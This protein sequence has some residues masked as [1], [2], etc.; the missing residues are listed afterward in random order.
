M[1]KILFLAANPQ[2]TTSLRLDEECRAIDQ[3]VRVSEFR[4]QF[5]IK[6]HWAVRIWD[7][8]ELLLRHTPHI[9]HFSG[10]G[11]KTNEIILQDNFGASQPVSAKA[12][13][14]LF[15]VLKD[16]IRCVVLNACYSQ[17]QA[18]AI[19][20]NIDC[21]VGM[22]KAILDTSAISFAAAFYRALGYGRDVKTAFD[23]GCLQID[24]DNLGM[25]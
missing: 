8:Q 24:L 14:K 21:V 20:K 18:E 3:A 25:V 6:S 4:D 15:G 12:L 9:V 22:S 7:L 13:E 5:D 19:A 2:D 1:I 23:L 10:H 17:S 16:N 11:S